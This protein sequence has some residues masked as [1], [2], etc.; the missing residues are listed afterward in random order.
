[1]SEGINSGICDS[2]YL[3]VTKST[4]MSQIVQCCNLVIEFSL[5][6]VW[7]FSSLVLKRIRKVLKGTKRQGIVINQGRIFGK[8]YIEDTENYFTL[9]IGTTLFIDQSVIAG[10]SNFYEV[11]F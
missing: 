1:M 9:Q 3:E 4:K 5:S 7:I 6:G 8:S 11:V 2:S 10:F